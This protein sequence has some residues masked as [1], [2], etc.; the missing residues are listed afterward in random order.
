[1]SL[2]VMADKMALFLVRRKIVE[3]DKEDIYSFGFEILMAT[4]LNSVLVMIAA[5][6]FGLFWQSVLMIFP[7]VLI[8][9]NAGGFHAKTHNGCML[10]FLLVYISIILFIQ[11]MPSEIS[12]IIAFTS[13]PLATG[14]ILF[15]GALPHKNR[16]VTTQEL[17]CFKSKARRITACLFV[18]GLIG[19]LVIPQWFIYFS[20]GIFIAA[21][22]LLVG[23]IQ[24]KIK[25]V[26][27]DGEN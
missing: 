4:I 2:H 13:L 5:L 24:I 25:G 3:K 11:W 27:N 23:C 26:R 15:I 14:L 21:G 17:N 19:L 20:F 12:R 8:R 18:I 10:G 22:S 7:F 6:M 16:P 1:M 9:N